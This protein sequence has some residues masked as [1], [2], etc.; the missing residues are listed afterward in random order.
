MAFFCKGMV[1]AH[2]KSPGIHARD[3]NVVIVRQVGGLHN[4]SHIQKAPVQ[5][6]RYLLGIPAV[7]VVAQA[8]ILLFEIHDH[9]CKVFNKM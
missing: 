8:G 7:D 4:N 9:L 6:F 5:T 3:R 1:L 2:E